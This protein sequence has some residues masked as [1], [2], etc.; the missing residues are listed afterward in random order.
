MTE[1]LL[2]RLRRATAAPV[3]GYTL[4]A[5]WRL[6]KQRGYVRVVGPGRASYNALYVATDRGRSY[7]VR[8]AERA[9]AR[10]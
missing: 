1:K 8:S 6:L 7:L 5:G 4:D 2:G 9:G 10:S 3:N